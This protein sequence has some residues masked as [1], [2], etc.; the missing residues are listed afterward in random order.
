[1]RIVIRVSLVRAA[2]HG[3]TRGERVQWPPDPVRL[4]GAL[5]NGAHAMEDSVLSKI[6]HDALKRLVEAPPPTITTPRH[7]QLEHP[8]TYTDRTGLPDRL[9]TTYEEKPL[10][11]LTLAPLSM[12]SHNR[13]AKPR[14]GV[15]LAGRVIDYETD[16][17]LTPEQILALDAAARHIPYFGRSEDAAVVEV[18]QQHDAAEDD[19]RVTWYP[20]PDLKGHSRGWQ[21]NTIEWMNENHSRVFSGD[22][23]M[24]SLPFLPTAGYVCPLT[25]STH[26]PRAVQPGLVILRLPTP[27][28]QH[29]TPNLLRRLGPLMPSGWR[30]LPLTASSH[31]NSD[32]HLVG[33]G[34]YPTGHP[35]MVGTQP[36]PF[37]KLEVVLGK[38]TSNQRALAT[39]RPDTWTG[40]ARRWTST[41]PL[42]GFPNL[43]ILEDALRQE[44]ERRFSIGIKIVEASTHARTSKDHRWS[45]SAY[46]DGYGL[47]WV[48]LEFARPITGPLQL[49]ITTEHGFGTFLPEKRE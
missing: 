14:D 20:C 49:G 21:P 30:I 10:R 39:L 38:P 32:G 2:Y 25:Y 6:A 18:L 15:A 8:P 47:W 36:L 24:S 46:T 40:P 13:T 3:L 5:K 35:D 41:T 31:R 23:R 48:T 4:L 9:S 19:S 29:Q 34:F 7:V 37:S 45:N 33:L 17:N 27:K 12:D 1:M 26:G 42:R 11:L 28:E 44:A 16:A 22:P 43:I